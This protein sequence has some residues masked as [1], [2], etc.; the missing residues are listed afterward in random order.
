MMGALTMRR[1]LLTILV[2]GVLAGTTAGVVF[3]LNYEGEDF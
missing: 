3:A 2:I 1:L